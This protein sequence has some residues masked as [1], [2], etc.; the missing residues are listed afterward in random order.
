MAI[1]KV[2]NHVNYY[3]LLHKAPLIGWIVLS[4]LYHVPQWISL[5]L[6][7]L[8]Q[9]ICITCN[10]FPYQLNQRL[11]WMFCKKKK[12]QKNKKKPP[13]RQPVY[14]W[15]LQFSFSFTFLDWNWSVIF[16][17][18]CD[19]CLLVTR[20]DNM[21]DHCFQAI[22]C[23][24]HE[25]AISPVPSMSGVWYNFVFV[26][27]ELQQ[28]MKLKVIIA[29]RIQDGYSLMFVLSS[30]IKCQT[31]VSKKLHDNTVW[32]INPTS[33]TSCGTFLSSSQETHIDEQ[34]HHHRAWHSNRLKL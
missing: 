14:C 23:S 11:K 4:V 28:T 18:R 8:S 26:M 2:F 12:Q 6:I 19:G 21:L 29:Y 10:S 33:A 31:S 7:Q 15:W 3:K 17:N 34:P 25:L 24:Y 30:F 13:N 20:H 1:K 22:S 16:H 27:L 5:S 32:T 9:K